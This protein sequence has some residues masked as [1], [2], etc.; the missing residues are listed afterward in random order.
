MEDPVT[1]LSGQVQASAVALEQ[2]D[3]AKGLLVVPEAP[4][5]ALVEDLVQD[6][7]SR[8]AERRMSEV[9]A[10]RDRFRQ[11]LVEAKREIPAVSSVWVSRVR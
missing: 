2:L 4:P 9:M 8:V 11:V 6:F 10:E 1:D 3:D 5:E 7:L